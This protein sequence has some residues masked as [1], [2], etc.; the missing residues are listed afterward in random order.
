MNARVD[1]A[2]LSDEDL[3]AEFR[4]ALSNQPNTDPAPFAAVLYERHF[5]SVKNWCYRIS[6]DPDRAQDMAQD[7]F[8]RLQTRLGSFKGD[9]RFATWLY[10]LTRRTAINF[11]QK[12]SNRLE[13]RGNEALDWQLD[14]AESGLA[15]LVRQ[16]QLE[17]VMAVV[18]SDLEPLPRQVIYLHYLVGMSL[19]AINQHLGLTNKS[20][21]KAHLVSAQRSLRKALA[22]ERKELES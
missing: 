3:I 18:N 8:L 13:D 11:L 4:S 12:V 10:S 16:E 15:T 17:K 5:E 14:T 1:L 22:R 21:A 9:S 7:V 2:N 20:G 6:G 19:S